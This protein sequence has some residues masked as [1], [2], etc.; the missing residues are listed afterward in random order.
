MSRRR[1]RERFYTID[2]NT[3]EEY[4]EEYE[5]MKKSRLSELNFQ[6]NSKENSPTNELTEVEE[7]LS[8]QNYQ[9]SSNFEDLCSDEDNLG[10]G[11]KH[12]LDDEEYNLDQ[13]YENDDILKG[14]ESLIKNQNQ[15]ME[16]KGLDMLCYYLKK[17]IKEMSQFKNNEFIFFNNKNKNVV[18][19]LSG[20]AIYDVNIR[21]LVDDILTENDNEYIKSNEGNN[22]SLKD[23]ILQNIESDK[24]LKIMIMSN[25]ESTKKSL[26]ETFFNIQN[27]KKLKNNKKIDKEENNINNIDEDEE[28]E[29][30]L[31]IIKKQI[32]IFNKNISL[33]IF[34]T[35]DEFH[36]NKFSNNYYE[37]ASAFF[38]FIEASKNNTKA[39][40]DFII[41]KLNNYIPNR[42]CVIFGINMLYKADCTIEGNNLR[43]YAN[44]KNLL[45]VPLKIN[46][47]N[48]QNYL[49]VNIFRLLVVRGINNKNNI[50]DSLRKLSSENKL[51]GIQNKLTDEIKNSSQKEDKYD[52]SK[53]NVES[54]LGYKKK[55]RIKHI[56]AFDMDDNDNIKKR[57]KLSADI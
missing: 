33:Q 17:S 30:T 16:E 48:M 50:K 29:K 18:N 11:V 49:I 22:N 42:I 23:Y 12:D 34:D 4:I 26:I 8:P 2:A 19:S 9:A 41:E 24:Y 20:N 39:Y 28:E 43:E 35:S 21:D 51:V 38:I 52:L 46:E 25:N 45:Y 5:N 56:N 47:F 14:D 37:H 15:N 40:L 57:R 32:K 13:I 44:D 36:K 6:N 1:A 3:K 31:D 10:L 7:A 53:M 54:S 27:N 55:Y